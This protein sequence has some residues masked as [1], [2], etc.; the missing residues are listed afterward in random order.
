MNRSILNPGKLEYPFKT[1]KQVYNEGKEAVK[2]AE[3]RREKSI[4]F[5]FQKYSPPKMIH[6]GDSGEDKCEMVSWELEL[7]YLK[8]RVFD[9]AMNLPYQMDEEEVSHIRFIIGVL[10]D[11]YKLDKLANWLEAVTANELSRLREERRKR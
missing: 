5:R 9:E 3:V 10:R 1:W 8:A 6:L 11:H 2:L 4:L 7:D